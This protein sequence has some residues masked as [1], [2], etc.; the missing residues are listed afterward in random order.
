VRKHR[1]KAGKTDPCKN[2]RFMRTA[3]FCWFPV[4]LVFRD[5]LVDGVDDFL[6]VNAMD[7]AGIR[8]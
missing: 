7:R 5:L 2:A 1:K 8:Q 3:R 6:R 4:L